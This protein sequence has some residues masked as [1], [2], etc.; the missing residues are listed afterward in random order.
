[1]GSNLKMLGSL[2]FGALLSDWDGGAV[3]GGGVMG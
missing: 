1:M 2:V 3:G